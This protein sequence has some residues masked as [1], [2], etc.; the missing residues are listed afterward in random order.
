MARI[1]SIRPEFW[2]H[3]SIAKRSMLARFVMVGLLTNADDEGRLQV[4]TD[5]LRALLFATGDVDAVKIQAALEELCEAGLIERYDLDGVP[6]ARVPGWSD[7]RSWAFQKLD[8]PTRSRLVPEGASSAPSSAA[9][10]ERSASARRGL[11]EDSSRTQRGGVERS[12][13]DR[14]TL[15]DG[16]G[17]G[18][19]GEESPPLPSPGGEGGEATAAPQDGGEDALT[20]GER[21]AATVIA[22]A[23]E[24]GDIALELD[25]E[26][27]AI[28]RDVA[29]ADSAV[30]GAKRA[31]DGNALAAAEQALER[32]SRRRRDLVV[33]RRA[34]AAALLR[35]GT[36]A[37]RELLE[38]WRSSSRLVGPP[39]R[40][41]MLRVACLAASREARGDARDRRRAQ[42][43]PRRVEASRPASP[44][45]QRPATGAIDDP[46]VDDG[47]D[48]ESDWA[49]DAPTNGHV[50]QHGAKGAT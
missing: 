10:D 50:L 48:A 41:V 23:I 43:P 6:C 31:G 21:A 4:D 18:R 24:H 26:Q 20:A 22:E 8:R 12:T 9:L 3:P 37:A 7:S 32:L 49:P 27:A 47:R 30:R 45:V 40:R 1:R 2:T 38:R 42:K 44:R 35:S 5:M 46:S 16:D 29:A 17:A 33:Q 36:S 28:E 14:R 19:G 13:S 11:V 39:E 25:D 15:V 34:A